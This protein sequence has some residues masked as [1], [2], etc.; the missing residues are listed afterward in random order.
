MI[1]LITTHLT[2]SLV[3][4]R[5]YKNLQMRVLILLKAYLCGM[6]VNFYH[7]FLLIFSGTPRCILQKTLPPT[8]WFVFKIITFYLNLFFI[9]ICSV[10]FIKFL[11]MMMSRGFVLFLRWYIRHSTVPTVITFF[12]NKDWKWNLAM[13]SW[14]PCVVF[15]ESMVLTLYE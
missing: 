2:H 5:L 14:A 7:A 1:K 9:Y 11:S 13:M 6:C 15:A 10:L 3:W 12:S 4:G 8:G